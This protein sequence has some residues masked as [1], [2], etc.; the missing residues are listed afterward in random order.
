MTEEPVFNVNQSLFQKLSEWQEKMEE[1]NSQEAEETQEPMP[2][3]TETEDPPTE[4]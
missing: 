4:T 2:T 1:V 3:E